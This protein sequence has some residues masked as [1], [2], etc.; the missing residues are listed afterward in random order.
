MGGK[1]DEDELEE[2]FRAKKRFA[3][4]TAVRGAHPEFDSTSACLS[5]SAGVGSLNG[6]SLG[7]LGV[8]ALE[9]AKTVVTTICG[10]LAEFPCLLSYLEV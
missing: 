10:S 3:S 8:L 5:L 4:V 1:H 2:P 7:L 9:F 6:R